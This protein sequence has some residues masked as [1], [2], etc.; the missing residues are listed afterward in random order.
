M[1][2]PLQLLGEI[3]QAFL[4]ESRQRTGFDYDALKLLHKKIFKM[5]QTTKGL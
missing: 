3:N 1:R 5:Y 2:Y 4:D